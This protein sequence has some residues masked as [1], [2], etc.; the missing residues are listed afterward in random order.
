[1]THPLQ[2][3]ALRHLPREREAFAPIAKSLKRLADGAVC[4]LA[5][6]ETTPEET[7]GTAMSISGIQEGAGN[8]GSRST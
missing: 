2:T 1:M 8:D 4:V 6:K 7:S 3:G 5:N